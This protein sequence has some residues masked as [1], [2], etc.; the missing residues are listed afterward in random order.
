MFLF[1]VHKQRDVV[2]LNIHSDAG[3]SDDDNEE[4]VFDFKVRIVPLVQNRYSSSG[5]LGLGCS[6]ILFSTW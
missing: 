1:A 6:E 5:E 4:P 2:P 3:E